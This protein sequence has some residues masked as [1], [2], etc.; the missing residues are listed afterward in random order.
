MIQH[1]LPRAFN[2]K[3][4]ITYIAAWAVFEAAM[5]LC[6]HLGSERPFPALSAALRRMDHAMD[7]FANRRSLVLAS[8]FL[9]VFV[10]RLALLPVLHVPPPRITD[11]F[12]QVLSGDTFAHWRATNP[13]HPMWFYFQTF[14]ENQKPTYHSM[15]LP[16]N[17]LFLALGQILT[18]IPW[19]GVLFSAAA[20][21]AAMCW[22]L[23]G[24]VTPRWALWGAVV[25]VLQAA[26]NHLTDR[27]VGE[28]VTILA[29]A[30]ILGAVPRIVKERK[31]A[32]A[33]WLGIGVALLVASR[34]YEGAFLVAG[35]G[36]GGIW[37]ALQEGISSGA[38]LR[39]V[40]LP[41]GLMLVPV[42]LSLGYID[43][44]TTGNPALPPYQ[45]NLVE[46]HVTRPFVWQKPVAPPHYDYAAMSSFYQQWEVNWWTSITRFPRGIVL[47]FVDKTENLYDEILWP[48]GALV[49]IGG[50]QLLKDRNRRFLPLTFGFFL[51][52]LCLET[53]Q[54]LGWYLGPVRAVVLLLA[55]YGVRHLGAWRRQSHHGLR[56]SRMVAVCVPAV[57][58][59]YLSCSLA[60]T[61]YGE[62]HQQPERYYSAR[63][64]LL[65]G[66]ESLPGKQLV[67]VRYSSSHI[68]FEEWVEN[69][70]DI[71][72]SKVVWARDVPERR[73]A[74][75]L[76][77]FKDRKVWLLEPDGE[78]LRLTPYCDE[79]TAPA[80]YQVAGVR[81]SCCDQ[82]SDH[83]KD[84]PI[85]R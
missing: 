17:G 9:M 12:S 20:A 11:E 56:I 18:G 25:F 43:W 39:K 57:L 55:V 21:A 65:E 61:A 29:G 14:M 3:D 64:R 51:V 76:E 33:G 63:Q 85:A 13:T 80:V 70:A 82:Q 26:K 4:P 41:V 53:Y 77:Y 19:L 49:A 75:L 45:L 83:S 10:G 30:L 58:L 15:Y 68:P 28:A 67:I 79:K 7:A 5:W 52:G 40:A 50:Y 1:V 44:R 8:V 72:A 6:I 59:V 42:F 23:Q 69:G 16:A 32:A 34:P 47:F 62:T 2:L 73:N 27:Y 38:I 54:L 35:V 81:V 66:L 84:G 24:W 46:Q 48:L 36:L 22:M 78:K 74:D 60:G 71:D 31:F 37:W